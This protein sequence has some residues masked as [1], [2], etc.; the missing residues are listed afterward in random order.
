MSLSLFAESAYAQVLPVGGMPVPIESSE[1]VVSLIVN[2]LIWIAPVA[3]ASVI[4][5]KIRSNRK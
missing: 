2:N 5:L 1:L 3:A 4:A